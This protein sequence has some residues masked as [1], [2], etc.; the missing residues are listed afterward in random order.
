MK[1]PNY[2]LTRLYVSL[3]LLF[4]L[5]FTLDNTSINNISISINNGSIYPVYGGV[6]LCIIALLDIIINDFLPDSYKF[7]H[8]SEYRHLIYMGISLISFSI[9]VPVINTFGVSALT[10]RNWLDGGIAA[11]IAVFDI[12][13]RHKEKR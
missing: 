9:S 8:G 12:F 10:G 5:I 2:I 4:S 3:S 6:F 13:A 7:Y 1:D 11:F